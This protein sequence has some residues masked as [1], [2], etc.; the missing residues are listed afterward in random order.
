MSRTSTA[1]ICPPVSS[2]CGL[3]LIL[4]VGRASTTHDGT[5]NHVLLLLSLLSAVVVIR[6][7]DCFRPRDLTSRAAATTAQTQPTRRW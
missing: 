7:G 5:A 4:F 1:V 2:S 3:L 6:K